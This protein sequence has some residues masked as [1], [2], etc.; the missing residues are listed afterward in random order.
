[1]MSPSCAT[2]GRSIRRRSCRTSRPATSPAAGNDHM[3]DER[4]GRHAGR[5]R[6]RPAVR[7][8]LALDDHTDDVAHQVTLSG[9]AP[10]TLYHYR[11][12]SRDAA[13]NL[14]VSGDFTFI[15]TSGGGGAPVVYLSD[16]F[17][18]SMTNGW[19]PVERDRSNGEVG[20]GRWRAASCSTAS[21][22]RRASVRTPMSEVVYDDSVGLLAVL[23]RGWRRR[24][25]RRE[26]SRAVP[27]VGRQHAAVPECGPDRQQ[28][29]G[30]GRGDA[31]RPRTSCAWS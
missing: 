15:T 8:Q 3:A 17:W 14:S 18:T 23:R 31:C 2:T 10:G 22:T 27:G 13:G 16:L 26:W 6:P 11:V 24:R 21:R 4:A 28:R 5:V 20:H 25:G 12:K 7:L 30:L 29:H 1:M 9:L 19:G